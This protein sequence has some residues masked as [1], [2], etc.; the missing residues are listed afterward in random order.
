MK[1]VRGFSH[2]DPPPDLDSVEFYSKSLTVVA[3]L[4]FIVELVAT[5]RSGASFGR[6]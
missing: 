6:C 3:V 1:R 4:G 5:L 2:S